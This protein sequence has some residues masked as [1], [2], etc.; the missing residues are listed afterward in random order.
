MVAKDVKLIE[1]SKSVDTGNCITHAIGAVL[2]VAALIA[3]I[4]S[5]EGTRRIISAIIYGITML[6][7]Y[8]ASSVY[9]GLKNGEA[10]RV[11]R[12]LDHSAIPLL[13]AGTTTPCALVALYDISVFHGTAVL[14]TAWFC[15]L[16]GLISKIFFFEKLKSVTMAVYIICCAAMLLSTIPVMDEM[17]KGSFELIAAGCITYVVGAVF[18]YLGIKREKLH[19]VFHLFVLL[20][21]AI[22]FYAIYTFIIR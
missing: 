17:E 7:V 19:I 4:I 2:S 9:H 15:A 12:L 6:T 1:Y 18:C 5:A 20:A 21:S 3:M 22:H 10:K 13:I 16:F 8:T 14:C 11:A